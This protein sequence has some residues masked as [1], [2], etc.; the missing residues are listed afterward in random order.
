MAE[1]REWAKAC[2][3]SHRLLLQPL[4]PGHNASTLGPLASGLPIATCMGAE[5]MGDALLAALDSPAR[6]LLVT[7]SHGVEDPA[8][9]DAR[10]GALVDQARKP[11]PPARFEDAPCT[12]GGLAVLFGCNTAGTPRDRRRNRAYHQSLA[13]I[14]GPAV[15]V[16]SHTPQAM[17][18][19][20]RGPLA[21]LA[22]SDILLS[23]DFDP[24][25]GRAPG[26]FDPP[27]AAFHD[28]IRRLLRGS[29]I[30][31]AHLA[32]KNVQN[33]AMLDLLYREVRQSEPDED[34][35]I[36]WCRWANALGW[37]VLGDPVA[38]LGV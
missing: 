31:A 37:M 10:H 7:A 2:A 8:F 18:M 22:H 38:R 36:D 35:V 28:V 30:G 34:Y 26:L 3:L 27:V 1:R 21:L 23:L 13:S 20:A 32:L 16:L 4:A 24:G 14:H 17:L 19:S 15:D 11:V 25:D 33:Q 6:Q 12:N 5:A 9:T 29:A